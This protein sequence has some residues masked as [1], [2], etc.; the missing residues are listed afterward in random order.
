MSVQDDAVKAYISQYLRKQKGRKPPES[1]DSQSRGLDAKADE[2]GEGPQESE[3]TVTDIGDPMIAERGSHLSA[4][5]GTP[6][7]KMDQRAVDEIS[8]PMPELS[9]EDKVRQRVKAEFAGRRNLDDELA[10]AHKDNG[11]R[12]FALTASGRGYG[13]FENE[14]A[15]KQ[16]MGADAEERKALDSGMDEL[17]QEKIRDAVMRQ[18]AAAEGYNGEKWYRRRMLD[19]E[20]K[21]S[22]VA[23]ERKWREQESSKNRAS[24]ERAARLSAGAKSDDKLNAQVEK[25]EKRIPPEASSLVGKLDTLEKLVG[26][27][28]DNKEDVPGVGFIAGH[29]P[30]GILSDE[31]EEVQQLSKGLLAQLLKMQ[32]GT[33]ASEHEV[34]RKAVELGMGPGSSDRQYR[35]GLRNLRRELTSTLKQNQSS[36]PEAAVQEYKKRG[37]LTSDAVEKTQAQDDSVVIISP[38]GKPKKIPKSQMDAAIKAGGRL[39]P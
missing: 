5:L 19:R 6:E 22:D 36:A 21:M 2:M 29:L 26:T 10:Q 17:R 34:N 13:E 3:M 27:D 16:R 11:W 38:N 20:D 37:G 14:Q 28:L 4:N 18:K 23:S 1:M 30:G 24:Q 31:G 15:I 8:A 12:R 35:M 33:A 32:S 39:A 25:L 9:M 7:L